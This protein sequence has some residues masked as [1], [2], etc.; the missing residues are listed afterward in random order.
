MIRNI[1]F[2]GIG[3]MGAPMSARLLEAG[4]SLSIWNRSANKCSALEAQGAYRATSIDELVSRVD[5]VCLCL[6][7]TQAVQ[8]VFAQM[9]PHLSSGQIIVDFSSIDPEATRELAVTALEYDVHWIDCPVSGGVPGAVAGTLA[10]MAGGDKAVLERLASVLAPLS[11]RVTY[12]GESGAGQYSKICNQMI[13][14]C[15]VLVIAEVIALA[16]KAGVNSSKLAEAFAGGFADSKPLQILA[17]EMAERRFEPIK[18][19]VKTLAKDL[20]MAV[21]HSKLVGSST[22]MS[23]LASQLMR[24]HASRGFADKDPSTLIELYTEAANDHHG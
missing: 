10:M 2:I 8:S 1:G 13:V 18:W 5:V 16:E 12:M 6:T 23:G 17:P 21:E 4:F 15:N 19:H 24:L 7:D 22:P 14:S 11:A 9:V 20:D 3:L